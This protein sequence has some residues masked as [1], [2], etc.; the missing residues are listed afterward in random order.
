MNEKYYYQLLVSYQGTNYIG[1]QEQ[2]DTQQTIQFVF[3]Q[4]LK[5][6]TKEYYH[7]RHVKS[8]WASRTDTGV[9]ALGQVARIS[10]PFKMPKENLWKALNFHLPADIRVLE[11]E[12]SHQ[13]FHPRM[14]V[15]WKE[16]L[17][18]FSF[19]EEGNSA[20]SSLFNVSPFSSHLVTHFPYHLDIELMKQGAELFVGTHNFQNF[21]NQGGV[22]STV[23]EILNSEILVNSLD[24]IHPNQQVWQQIWYPYPLY[25]FRIRSRG[26][27]KQ[28][29]R[30]MMGYLVLVGRKKM[31][32]EIFKSAL[33]D[34]QKLTRKLSLS[35][36]PYGLYL[37][38]IS[39]LSPSESEIESEIESDDERSVKAN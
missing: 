21:Y 14:N 11:V 35:A 31:T 19:S 13:D 16:Y 15:L 3:N 24:L 2:K 27:L 7:P 8:S 29:V 18:L 39:Y 23:R 9:H 10:L 33:D 34:P 28:M 1:L 26:F 12:E 25:V 37:N 4:V 30:L 38:K 5:K 6:M 36:P 17:Y 20:S 22:K 32:M